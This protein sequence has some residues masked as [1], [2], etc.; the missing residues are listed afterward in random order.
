MYLII[1]EVYLH[2][3]QKNRYFELV[4]QLREILH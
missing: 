4:A 2:D 1:F 3:V